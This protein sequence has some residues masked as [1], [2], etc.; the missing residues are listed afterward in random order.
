VVK[1]IGGGAVEEGRGGRKLL[2]IR[3]K[4]AEE[5]VEEGKARSSLRLEGFERKGPPIS[6]MNPHVVLYT[7]SSAAPLRSQH[8]LVETAV[9]GTPLPRRRLILHILEDTQLLRQFKNRGHG[10]HFLNRR[11][12]HLLRA[13]KTSSTAFDK[14]PTGPYRWE[15]SPSST[16]Y[17]CVTWSCPNSVRRT[18]AASSSRHVSL[19]WRASARR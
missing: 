16:T 17:I 4:K 6:R 8:P 7:H 10:F 14:A 2:R 3:I 15:T 13:V 11:H 18:G 19:G 5:V 9:V 12:I 1:V